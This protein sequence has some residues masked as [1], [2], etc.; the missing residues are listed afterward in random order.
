MSKIYVAYD[1]RP[2]HLPVAVAD[3]SAQLA[4]LM[5]VQQKTV[6]SAIG[7]IRRGDRKTTRYAVVEVENENE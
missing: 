2:P 3:S 4:R 1:L 7:Q 5:G 6:C